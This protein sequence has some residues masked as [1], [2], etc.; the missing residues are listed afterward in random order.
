MICNQ[1]YAS[2]LEKLLADS[3]FEFF[4]TGSRFFG[5]VTEK[6]DS[7]FFV[8]DSPLV[9]TFLEGHGFQETFDH[10]YVDKG[11]C[12]VYEGHGGYAFPKLH[13]Q[14]VKNVRV[15]QQAQLLIQHSYLYMP[16]VPKEARRHVWDLAMSIAAMSLESEWPRKNPAMTG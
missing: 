14:L 3:T 12:S 9:R 10:S 13:V 16:A 1:A 8:Q 15:K 6:S 5:G 2:P 7:D 4:I 11:N